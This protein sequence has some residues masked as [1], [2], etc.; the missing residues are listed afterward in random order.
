MSM[1][2]ARLHAQATVASGTG[3]GGAQAQRPAGAGALAGRVSIAAGRA[4]GRVGP[5]RYL[6]SASL[7]VTVRVAKSYVM[8]VILPETNASTFFLPGHR[9]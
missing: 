9:T 7:K 2:P 3:G 5:G 8:N 1:P 4:V 6:I